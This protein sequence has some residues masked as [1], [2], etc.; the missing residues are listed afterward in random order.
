LKADQT[1]NTVDASRDES[2][3]AVRIFWIESLYIVLMPSFSLV[4]K[5]SLLVSFVKIWLF[6]QSSSLPQEAA[7]QIGLWLAFVV[8]LQT[9]PERIIAKYGSD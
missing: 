2:F 5:P 1:L 7:I 3:S 6:R 8:L 4:L 9:F